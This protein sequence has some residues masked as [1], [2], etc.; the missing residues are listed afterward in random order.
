MLSKFYLREREVVFSFVY[1]WIWQLET[2][3]PVWGGYYI[4]MSD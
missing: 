4:R 1:N 2:N 3:L